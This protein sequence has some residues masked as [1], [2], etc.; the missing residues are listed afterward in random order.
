[1]TNSVLANSFLTLVLTPY[2]K[3]FEFHW[4]ESRQMIVGTNA[5]GTV[6]AIND[7]DEAIVLKE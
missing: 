5:K 7:K 3:S 4:D 2:L 6:I 1:M